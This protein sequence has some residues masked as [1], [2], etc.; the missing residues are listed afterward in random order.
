MKDDKVVIK[1]FFQWLKHQGYELRCFQ[2]GDHGGCD[3]WHAVNPSD[4]T[5][6]IKEFIEEF[7]EKRAKRSVRCSKEKSSCKT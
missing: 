2:Y 6:L 3:Y 4:Q 7:D 1:A 5:N